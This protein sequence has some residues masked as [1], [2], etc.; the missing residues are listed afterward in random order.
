MYMLAYV[1]PEMAV[2]RNRNVKQSS[3]NQMMFERE[4]RILELLLEE[5][6]FDEA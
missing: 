2:F 4:A 3:Y 1:E 5:G 6:F